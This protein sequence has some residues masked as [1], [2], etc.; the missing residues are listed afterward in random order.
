MSIS[1]R[2]FAH[3]AGG[4]VLAGPSLVGQQPTLTAQQVVERVQKN[5]GIPWQPQNLSQ[6]NQV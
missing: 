1:R 3:L 4:A 6:A 2:R 5:I